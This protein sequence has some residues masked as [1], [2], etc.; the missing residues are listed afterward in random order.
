MV[1]KREF[2]DDKADIVLRYNADEA[3]LL[4]KK[5]ALPASIKIEDNPNDQLEEDIA[6][7][8]TAGDDGDSDSD[9]ED[10]ILSQP[11]NR[12]MLPPSDSEDSDSD[13]EVNLDEL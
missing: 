4:K 8:F 1:S 6:F 9:S 10:E 5:G 13:D 2:Q 7:D 11:T 3:R 12:G